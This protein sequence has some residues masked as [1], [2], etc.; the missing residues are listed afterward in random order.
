MPNLDTAKFEE[1]LN[2]LTNV[3]MTLAKVTASSSKDIKDSS[4][5]FDKSIFGL[6][7]KSFELADDLASL[8]GKIA[9]A[10][11]NANS[12]FNGMFAKFRKGMVGFDDFTKYVI[13]GKKKLDDYN[14]E[15]E[16][17]TEVASRASGEELDAAKEQLA[18]LEANRDQLIAMRQ[19][20]A[21]TTFRFKDMALGSIKATFS[22]GNIGKAL[23]STANHFLSFAKDALSGDPFGPT[24]LGFNT[25]VDVLNKG[26]QTAAKGVGA[27]GAAMSMI[28]GPVGMVGTALSALAPIFGGVSEAVSKLAKDGF[29]L[30]T[31]Q[32][33]K[34]IGNFD[35]LN[36]SGMFAA[37][38]LTEMRNMAGKTGLTLDQ[39]TKVT[40][41]SAD[42]LITI[43]G[44]VAGGA[45]KMAETVGNFGDTTKRQLMNLGYSFEDMAEGT[46]DYMESMKLAGQLDKMTTQEQAQGA[47][48]YLV[49]QRLLT[50]ITGE[51][52]KAAQKRAKDAAN[53]AAVQAKLSSMDKDSRLKYEALVKAAGP[54]NQKAVEQLFLFGSVTGDAA[55]ALSGMPSMMKYLQEGV[56]GVGNSAVTADQQTDA[57]R[58]NQQKYGA[59][60]GKE[61]KQLGA[62]MGTASSAVGAHTEVANQASAGQQFAARALGASAEEQR[63]TA[64]DAADTQD[65]ATDSLNKARVSAQ[66]LAVGLEEMV[67]KALPAFGKITNVILDSY[68]DVF[69]AIRET[70]GL[71]KGTPTQEIDKGQSQV[72]ATDAE[73]Q[74]TMEGATIFQRMGFGRTQ[75]Q[76]AA[77]LKQYEAQQGLARARS[78]G[79]AETRPSAAIGGVLEGSKRGF[80]ATLHGVEAVVP[81]PENR[82]IPVELSGLNQLLNQNPLNNNT[83]MVDVAKLLSDQMAAHTEKFDD[84]IKIMQRTASYTGQ[85]A[86]NT[87]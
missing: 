61:A 86:D 69:D 12:E 16:V 44:T 49:N 65:A 7:K 70:L 4:A 9:Y 11:R 82:S 15:I 45:K 59:A 5:S 23:D 36:Q 26:A 14:K 33:K 87:L 85:L 19:G 8:G 75:E 66:T 22:I 54:G 67:I 17:L 21:L 80:D 62:A 72:A 40:T 18:A 55:V 39:F 73:Y 83:G 6:S 2:N 57:L 81:L 74:K 56:A 25:A 38:G 10:G 27:V 29:G 30:M 84:M 41:Q 78:G 20:M 76:E 77:F 34:M 31:E 32:A 50:S 1:Q 79:A 35:K 13:D 52:A 43:G 46:A 28:P 47:K 24:Q 37:G 53:Q 48:D 51:E 3:I 63:K 68:K 60:I 58:E 71:K 42:K 64:S